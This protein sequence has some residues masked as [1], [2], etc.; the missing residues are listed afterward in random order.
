MN[1]H[2]QYFIWERYEYFCDVL[3]KIKLYAQNVQP[4]IHLNVVIWEGACDFGLVSRA[5]GNAISHYLL[6][7]EKF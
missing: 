3:K 1:C 6:I 7:F 4:K 2:P 5:S